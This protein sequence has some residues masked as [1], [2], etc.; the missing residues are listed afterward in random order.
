MIAFARAAWRRDWR[1]LGLLAVAVAIATAFV[2]TAAIGARRAA[3]AWDRFAQTTESPD[4]FKEVPVDAGRAALTDVRNRPGVRVAASMGFMV[5]VPEGRVPT[6][7]QAPGAFVG[8][9]SGFGT[10]LY[11]P[12]I[13]RGRAADQARADELTINA[14]M[15]ALT[16]LEPGDEVT[17]A[18]LPEAVHQ[19]ATVVGVHAGPLDVTLNSSQPLALLT[20]AFGAAW[21]EKYLDLLPAEVRSGYTTVVMAGLRGAEGRADM[22]AEGFINGREFGSEAIAG[23]DAQR[24]AFTALALAGAAGTLLALGQAVSRRIRRDADQLP[25]LT[26]LGLTPRKRQTAIA[27]APCAAA[28]LGLAAAPFIA[29]FASPVVSTGV[30]DLLEVGRPKVV[31]LAVMGLGPALGLVVI[32]VFAWSAVSRADTRSRAPRLRPIP[33]R[34][35][36]PSGLFGGRVAAGWAT[37]AARTT[38]RSHLIGVIAGMAV[39]TGVAVWAMTADHVVSTPERY[40]VTWDATIRT[41]EEQFSSDPVAITTAAE[42]LG[43]SPEIGSPVARVIAGMHDSGGS[44]ILVIDRASGSWWP[45]IVAG[46]EPAADNE[47]TVG[48]GISDVGLGDTVELYGRELPVVGRHVVIPL[49]NGGSGMSIAMSAGAISEQSLNVPDE[50]LLVDLA[51]D[52]TLDDVRRLIGDG[53]AVQAAAEARP[54]DIANLGRT[55]GLIQVLLVAC[56]ALTLAEFANG[57]IVA[58]HARRRDHATLRALG[59]RWRTVT[60]SIAW[61][62]GLVAFLG[63]AVGVPLGLVIGRTVWRRT[64]TGINAVPDLWRWA[65]AAA[66]I[67]AATFFACAVVVAV[68]AVIPR[69]RPE[70]RPRE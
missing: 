22:Q 37:P 64:A 53:L 1:A 49:S 20:S 50:L 43:A 4:V 17:L 13:L 62:G 14:A 60:G 28:V 8:L 52:A 70:V 41:D 16:G 3:S 32:A 47:I 55:S 68:A 65:I 19:P 6:D 39:I 58:T 26:A 5:V 69:R 38:A 33:I 34:L 36:G 15:A 24:T 48:M 35:P 29:Y 31:D 59:A 63:A 56:V 54:G 61:H 42:R 57:L 18:S 45:Q 51:P 2:I 25:I 10:D 23:L 7:A 30:T 27:A 66:A 44:E 46:R 40:G 12:L 9:S 21:F 11:R 67:T